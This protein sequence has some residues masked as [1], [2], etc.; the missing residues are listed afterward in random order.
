MINLSEIY[1]NYLDSLKEEK[2][3][4]PF[5]LFVSDVGKCP[6][7][8]ACRMLGTEKNPEAAQSVFNRNIMFDNALHMESRMIEALKWDGRL[9]AE[10][11]DVDVY[12]H[13]NWGGR[14]DIIADVDGRRVIEYKTANSNAFRHDFDR[15]DYRLQASVYDIYCRELYTLTARPLIPLFDRGGTNTY[16]WEE[17]N[18]SKGQVFY[19][20]N[21]LDDVRATMKVGGEL[22]PKLGKIL[23]KR[24]YD[25]E[26]VLEPPWDCGWCDYSDVCKPETGKSVWARRDDNRE[27]WT[28]CRA[29]DPAVLA[30]WALIELENIV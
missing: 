16:K 21:E 5:R 24:S 28:V 18:V 14:F 22:P 26:L 20:M 12:D 4:D 27:P 2:T 23:K 9:I 3:R 17:V 10:Q 7:Q 8:V 13:E 30:N 11:E 15:D 19:L 25:K 1:S 29:A 6:R